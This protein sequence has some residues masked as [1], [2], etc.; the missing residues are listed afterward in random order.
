MRHAERVGVERRGAA[1]G[2]LPRGRAGELEDHEVVAPG[3]QE[4]GRPG[5][6]Q[7]LGAGGVAE[8]AADEQQARPALAQVGQGVAQ[9]VGFDHAR[10]VGQHA[11]QPA[12]S[13]DVAVRDQDP[14][15]VAHPRKWYTLAVGAARHRPRF[16]TTGAVFTLITAAQLYAP[17]PRGRRELLVGA[18]R[19]LAISD[20]DARLPALPA[21]YPVEVVD[22]GGRELIPGLVDAHVHLGGGGGESGYASRV[23]PS[24]ARRA[25]HRR[26][27]QRRRLPRHRHHHSHHARPRRV[28]AGAP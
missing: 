11:R 5:L 13:S 25:G 26:R 9:G 12:A 7:Q 24:L 19:V 21:G 16:G 2:G 4:P 27:D 20:E 18:G 10:H 3:R 22:A 6:G 8:L 23:P 14:L 1:W 17:A 28:R 15:P